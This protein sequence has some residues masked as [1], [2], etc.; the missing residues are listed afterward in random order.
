MDPVSI[1]TA[2][3]DGTAILT[4]VG[5]ALYMDQH[6]WCSPVP[7]GK[8]VECDPFGNPFECADNGYSVCI[9]T[10]WTPVPEWILSR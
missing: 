1:D 4:D 2:P 10:K 8:W 6:N 3:R 7:H 5:F 9:P